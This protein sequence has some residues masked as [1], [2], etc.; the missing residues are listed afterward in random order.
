[1]SKHIHILFL[2]LLFSISNKAQL[3][4]PHIKILYDSSWTYKNLKLIPIKII[5]QHEN[6]NKAFPF[7]SSIISLKNAMQNK[8]VQVKENVYAKDANV[9]TI[10]IKNLSKENILIVSGEMLK[11]GKQDRIIAETKILEPNKEAEYVS[12]FCIEKGRW[13]KKQ[14]PF[15]YAGFADANLRKAAD[16]TAIQQHVWQEIEQQIA[17]ENCEVNN[18]SYLQL[19]AKKKIVLD[20]YFKFFQEKYIKTDST[21]IGFIAVTD[22]NIIACDVFATSKLLS[23]QYDN[24]LSGYIQGVKHTEM[25]VQISPT[26]INNF[27]NKVFSSEQQQK[28]YLEHHGKIY[29]YKNKVVQITAYDN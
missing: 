19:K 17:E 24:I 4:F 25:Q 10:T 15:Y 6:S 21:I 8:K 1:M 27:T 5:E 12:V 22:S 29:T 23:L 7:N 13:S 20:D 16:S 11:G 26:K 9:N 3:V 14:K 2:F 18:E 28:K